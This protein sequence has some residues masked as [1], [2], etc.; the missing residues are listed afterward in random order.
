MSRISAS[1]FFPESKAPCPTGQK[2]EPHPKDDIL[3]VKSFE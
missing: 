2:H 3:P 1:C